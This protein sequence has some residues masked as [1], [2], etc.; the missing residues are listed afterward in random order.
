MYGEQDKRVQKFMNFNI[1]QAIR[2]LWSASLE[3][4]VLVLN[5]LYICSCGIGFC[6]KGSG[7][8]LVGLTQFQGRE[9]LSILLAP[10]RA[11]G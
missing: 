3:Q 9:N 4:L 10:S 6:A 11:D 1:R 7:K 5:M 2:V 8:F